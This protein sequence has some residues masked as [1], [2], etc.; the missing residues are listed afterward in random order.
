MRVGFDNFSHP[1]A[2]AVWAISRLFSGEFARPCLTSRLARI[3]SV[4]SAWFSPLYGLKTQL[5]MGHRTRA[6]LSCKLR[7]IS[8]WVTT[9]QQCTV[10]RYVVMDTPGGSPSGAFGVNGTVPTRFP[11]GAVR[12]PVDGYYSLNLSPDSDCCVAVRL[13]CSCTSARTAS[14]R[15]ISSLGSLGSTD[16]SNPGVKSPKPVARLS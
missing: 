5:F 6:I 12:F 7:Q 4:L 9:Q 10:A 3:G 16:Q 2:A 11:L 13:S 8:N 15:R 1:T 14:P